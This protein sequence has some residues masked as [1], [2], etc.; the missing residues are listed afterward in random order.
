[1]K[2]SDILGISFTTFSIISCFKPIFGT[3][4]DNQLISPLLAFTIIIFTFVFNRKLNI[5]K[6]STI[7]GSIFLIAG[8]LCIVSIPFCVNDNVRIIR[9]AITYFLGS[10]VIIASG[11][12]LIMKI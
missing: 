5:N 10:S 1:M 11:N 9:H 12:L 2:V 4:T 3:P 6:S 8:I 7:V